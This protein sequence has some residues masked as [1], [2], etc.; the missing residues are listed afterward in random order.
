MTDHDEPAMEAAPIRALITR[1]LL[2]Q[3]GA[4]V[5]LASG[6]PIATA[7]AAQNTVFDFESLPPNV[8][9]HH[10]VADGYDASVLIRWGDPI[11]KGSRRFN[12]ARLTGQLQETLFGFNCD[13]VAFFPLPKGSANSHRGLLF[14]NHEYAIHANMLPPSAPAPKPSA[15]QAALEQ[16]AMGGSVIEVQRGSD[17]TWNVVKNS[18]RAR[19]ITARTP[20]AIS[21]PAAGS[22]R[23]RTKADRKGRRVFGMLANCAGGKTPWGTA[24]TAEENFHFYFR[25]DVPKNHPEAESLAAAEVGGT[26][27]RTSWGDYDRRFNLAREPREANRFGWMVEVDPYSPRSMPIKRTALG[28]FR[29]EAAS[30]VINHD[31]RVV[32]YLGEDRVWGHVFRFVS[33]GKYSAKKGALNGELLDDGTL[34]AARFDETKVTWLPLVFGEG[35]LT[36]DNGFRSQADVLIEASKAAKAVGATPMDRPEDIETSPVSGHVFVNLTRNTDRKPEQIDRPNPRAGNK[37]GHILELVPPSTRAGL[38][39]AADE[40]DWS[41]LAVA[42][43]VD[44]GGKYGAPDA[45]VFSGPDNL[46]FDPKGRLW[47]ATDNR[48]WSE[49]KPVPNG[50]FACAVTGPQRAVTRF[51]FNVPAGAE[52]C[53]PEFT[54]DGTTLFLAVQHPAADLK[55]RPTKAWPDFVEGMPARPSLVVVTRKGGG[56]IGG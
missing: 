23:L 28:R 25:G 6:M 33:N 34:Y 46:A 17:G 24:L 39:H 48:R 22:V 20:M 47:I 51:F 32:V 3:S 37:D 49:E 4:A 16:A 21:G 50:L 2:L 30:V 13:F 10:K 53:G 54:P 26:Q 40:F 7:M 31:R 44:A 27:N 8:I 15:E 11:A 1:R 12:P 35:P 42:G 52:M 18:R 29:H 56:M 45:A 9:D 5:A 38:D 14:V 43:P 36:P 19:R 41:V 55:P